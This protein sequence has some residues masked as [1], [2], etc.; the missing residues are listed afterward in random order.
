VLSF[1]PGGTLPEKQWQAPAYCFTG[2]TSA[3]DFEFLETLATGR[4]YR[5]PA[6]PVPRRAS[7]LL[8]QQ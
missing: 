3:D 2:N 4:A 1:E 8:A 7:D 5:M 6:Q